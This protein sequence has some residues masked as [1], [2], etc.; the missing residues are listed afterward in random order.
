MNGYAENNSKEQM[1]A[2]EEKLA[3]RVHLFYRV[4]RKVCVVS[5]WML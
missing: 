1:L 3:P 5:C 4:R 2:Q